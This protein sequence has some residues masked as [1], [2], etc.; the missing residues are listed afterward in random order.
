M[1]KIPESGKV[2]NLYIPFTLNPYLRDKNTDFTLNNC[3]FGAVKPTKNTDPDKYKYSKYSHSCSQFSL[4]A[5][6]KILIFLHELIC[7]LGIVIIKNRYRN[8]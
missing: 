2:I 8:S 4:T 7:H 1:N 3:L 6:V 5:W